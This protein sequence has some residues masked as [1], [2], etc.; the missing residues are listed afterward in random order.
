MRQRA[1]KRKARS[2][3]PRG[4]PVRRSRRS[5]AAYRRSSRLS[6]VYLS[7]G[8]SIW[9]FDLLGVVRYGPAV[10]VVY[11]PSQ[12]TGNGCSVALMGTRLA[13]IPSID[14]LTISGTTAFVITYS[15]YG[16]M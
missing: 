5:G 4:R 13:V 11:R 15:E 16:L 14:D 9:G 1:W 7:G 10:K 3:G 6:R 8:R 12:A 2:S